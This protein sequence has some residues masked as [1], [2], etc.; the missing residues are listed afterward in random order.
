LF[1]NATTLRFEPDTFE[2]GL[3][4][5]RAYVSP[6]MRRQ[7]GLLSLALI[8]HPADQRI[9]ILS[10]WTSLLHARALEA[11][12]EY[13]RAVSKLDGLVASKPE[14]PGKAPIIKGYREKALSLN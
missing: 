2:Q 1:E 14:L 5:L 7:P 6:V 13:R 8:P 9:T 3:R 11:N 12:K 10:L 4:I